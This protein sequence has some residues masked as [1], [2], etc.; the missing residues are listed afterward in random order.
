MKLFNL[1]EAL[2]GKPVIT[3]AGQKVLWVKE[4][5]A[6]S[7]SQGST[8]LAY[9]EGW[10]NT[11]RYFSDGKFYSNGGHGSDLFMETTKKTGYINIYLDSPGSTL[12]TKGLGLAAGLGIFDTR[13][14]ADMIGKNRVA[15]AT[16]EYEE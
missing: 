11:R 6:D 13:E 2:A 3:R 1:E 9:A 15:L 5:P 16:F 12:V 10:F 14:Q 8:V 4:V 7:G